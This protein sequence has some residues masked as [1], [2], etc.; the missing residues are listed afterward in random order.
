MEMPFPPFLV[1]NGPLDVGSAVILVSS[2]VKALDTAQIL[3]QTLLCLRMSVLYLKKDCSLFCL[4]ATPGGAQILLLVLC[5]R[6][7]CGIGDQ[8]GVIVARNVLPLSHSPNLSGPKAFVM[9]LY[10]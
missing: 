8:S 9:Q 2:P 4:W 1:F 6:I 3:A 10:L 5:S 7:M